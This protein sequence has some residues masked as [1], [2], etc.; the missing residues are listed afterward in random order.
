MVPAR[1]VLLDAMGT[2]V[3]LERPWPHLVDALGRRGVGISE[4]AA[5]SAMLAEIAYYREHHDEAADAAGV[6]DL[7]DRC[8][9][10]LGEALGPIGLDAHEL[11]AAM[12]EALVFRPYPEVP[13]VLAALRDAGCVLV[14][15]SNWDYSL[16]EVLD[17]TG[18]AGLVDGVVISA[19]EGVSKPDARIFER[20]LAVA[21]AAAQDAVHVGDDLDVDVAGALAA[22]V[23]PVFV[24]RDG[25][26]GAPAGVTAIPDLGH[27]LSSRC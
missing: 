15:V 24:D 5:R 9:A 12:L 20:G 7:R 14:V 17:R 19:L 16:L 13:A 10:V 8:A 4:A 26:G 22:G 18:L 27:L 3:Q 23:R 21:G 2:L 11:R 25:T 1:A 6:E